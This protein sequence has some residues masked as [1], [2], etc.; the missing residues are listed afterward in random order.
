MAK[1]GEKEVDC[2]PNSPDCGPFK[3]VYG[4]GGS[5]GPVTINIITPRKE[6]KPKED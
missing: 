3:V 2:F 5:S 4:E 6:E 1:K